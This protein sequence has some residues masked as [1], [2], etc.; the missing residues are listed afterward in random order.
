VSNGAQHGELWHC[1]SRLLGAGKQRYRIRPEHERPERK[2]RM[3]ELDRLGTP[4]RNRPLRRY[5]QEPARTAEPRCKP[6]HVQ[7]PGESLASIDTKLHLDDD[8]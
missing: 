6:R 2:A 3:P 8:G 1:C 7:R 5:D 4:T